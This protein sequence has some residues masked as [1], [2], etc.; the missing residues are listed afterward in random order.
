VT[1]RCDRAVRVAAAT[2]WR[3]RSVSRAG[4]PQARSSATASANS[5]ATSSCSAAISRAGSRLSRASAGSMSSPSVVSTCAR[6]GGRAM[7]TVSRCGPHVPLALGGTCMVT[8]KTSQAFQ[9]PRTRSSSAT[10]RPPGETPPARRNSHG[11]TSS[12]SPGGCAV[13]Q[14][15][16]E[17]D[18]RAQVAGTRDVIDRDRRADVLKAPDLAVP[19]LRGTA[20]AL[21]GE[22]QQPLGR[23][24]DL[25]MRR[26]TTIGPARSSVSGPMTSTPAP[27]PRSS[28]NTASSARPKRSATQPRISRGARRISVRSLR[29]SGRRGSSQTATRSSSTRARSRTS[30]AAHTSPAKRSTATPSTVMDAVPW[31]WARAHCAW[32]RARVPSVAALDCGATRRLV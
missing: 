6:A 8:W 24:T 1:G 19:V 5:S 12:R 17:R 32:S 3:C 13:L 14:V 7:I 20:V 10:S 11:S 26:G 21:D 22:M 15:G 4:S 29:T 2:A 28:C 27:A 9:S 31:A 30:V 16:G 18:H 25:L 23:H